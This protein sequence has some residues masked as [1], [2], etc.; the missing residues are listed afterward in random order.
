MWCVWESRGRGGER[1]IDESVFWNEYDDT[2]HDDMCE[3]G[4]GGEKKDVGKNELVGR[5]TR[6]EFQRAVGTKVQHSISIE[7]LQTIMRR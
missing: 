4:R 2:D 7:Y 5:P 1:L 6:H 3:G